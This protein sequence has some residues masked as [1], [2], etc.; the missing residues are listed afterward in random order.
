METT[1]RNKR[2]SDEEFFR[3][4][5]EVL[6]EW[7]TGKDVDLDKAIEY[8]RNMPPS[9]NMAKKHAEARKNGQI[10]LTVMSGVA[11]VDQ[12]IELHRYQQNE[13][14]VDILR[15]EED[16]LTK[17]HN[18]AEAEKAVE[19]AERTGKNTL[20]GFPVV[21]YGVA[22]CRKLIE[23]VEQPITL[24][25][26]VIDQRLICEIG[27]AAG[28]S[29]VTSGPLSCFGQYSKNVPL[30]ALI[31]YYQ[32]VYRL[33]G[34]YEERGV[35][36][37]YRPAGQVE[38][39]HSLQIA[40][41]L[42]E[43]LLAAEQGTKN[44]FAK[45]HQHSGNLAQDIAATHV[46]RKL[47]EEYLAKLGYKDVTVYTQCHHPYGKFPLDHAQAYAIISEAPILAVLSG[48]DSFMVFTIDEAWTTPTKENSAA[49]CRFARMLLNLWQ[50]QAPQF[51]MLNNK[52]V[53]EEAEEIEK[54]S[55]A[56]IERVLELGDGD[57]AVG[58]IR[59]FETGE[60]D[61]DAILYT[62][63]FV[64]GNV[65]QV[66]DIR[67]ARRYLDTGNLPFTEEMKEFHRQKIAERSRRQGREVD[68]ETII[69]D[70]SAFSWGEFLAGPD[71]QEKQAAMSG[72]TY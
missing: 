5:E 60:L 26:S 20:N 71:W 43:N 9:K 69:G 1:V 33:M 29:G 46:M 59:A 22:G 35:P 19:E 15:L 11:T 54:E 44:V 16:T 70:W 10:L 4:R 28:L 55:R 37:M 6:A 36:M 47:N 38:G 45:P 41:E 13:G 62:S 61:V 30:E 49:S 63:Q 53:K 40:D 2:L 8:H 56:I 17:I 39:P 42:I 34:Y 25:G 18:Y 27:F 51:D 65:L 66:R 50:E 14:K 23:A 7:P 32:Y 67:G 12:Q 31:R 57:C 68:Y 72:R 3:E 58:A 64:K 48:A 24:D 52:A 21:T